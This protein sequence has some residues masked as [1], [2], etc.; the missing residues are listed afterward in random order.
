MIAR[1]QTLVSRN[2][3]RKSIIGLDYGTHSTKVVQ[4]Y[5]GDAV[6]QIVSFDQP[7]AGYPEHASPSMV[8]ELEGRLYFGTTAVGMAGA[9]Q[10]GSLKADLMNDLS[11]QP[12][13]AENV[14]VLAVAYIA[15]AL[16]QMI[17]CNPTWVNDQKDVQISAPTSFVG[18]TELELKYDRI[19]NAACQLAIEGLGEISQGICYED[20]VRI[21]RP[22]LAVAPPTREERRFSIQPETIAP[23]ISLQ[24]EPIRPAGT[25]LMIDMGASTTEVSVIAVPRNSSEPIR[26]YYDSTERRGGDN[27]AEIETLAAGKS[28]HRLESFLTELRMQASKVWQ[29]GFAKDAKNRAARRNWQHLTVLLTGGA[30]RHPSVSQHLDAAKKTP[31]SWLMH[32]ANHRLSRHRPRTL[33]PATAYSNDD[34]S[35]YA[36]ANGLSIHASQW[37]NYFVMD[38]IPELDSGPKSQEPLVRSY[39]EMS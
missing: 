27:L 29:V 24:Q 8:S 33:R 21:I 7:L 23:I 11:D 35:L 4:R 37:Q 14:E 2:Y 6:G 1:S 19:C 31:F 34:L 16:S 15:W 39:L 26:C 5:W 32:G 12:E 3:Q 25:Y 18:N 17:A 20:A 10:Y 22:L 36:V 28:Q 38:A 30:T 13:L 9:V